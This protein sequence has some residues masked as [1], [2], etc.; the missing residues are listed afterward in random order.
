ML[1]L[2]CPN[3]IHFGKKKY[4]QLYISELRNK[5]KFT[6]YKISIILLILFFSLISYSPYVTLP[7]L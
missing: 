6:L 7:N 3:F 5:L 1:N 4:P 2:I